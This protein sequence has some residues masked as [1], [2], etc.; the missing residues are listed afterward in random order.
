[1]PWFQRITP[2]TSATVISTPTNDF[3]VARVEPLI[4]N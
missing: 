3:I 4:E 1:M 2:R